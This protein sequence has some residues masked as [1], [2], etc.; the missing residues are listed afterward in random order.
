MHILHNTHIDQPQFLDILVLFDIVTAGLGFSPILR[1]RWHTKGECMKVDLSEVLSDLLRN[2]KTGLFSISVIDSNRLFKIFIREGDVYRLSFGNLR[3]AGCLAQFDELDFR[4]S[5]FIPNVD[6]SGEREAIPPTP[7][8]LSL[9]KFADKTVY[10]KKPGENGKDSSKGDPVINL[11]GILEEMKEAFVEQVGPAGLKFFKR[12]VDEKW[13]PGPT[14][15]RKDL[16]R[17]SELLKDVIED[18][19]DRQTFAAETI[20]ILSS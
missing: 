15:V 18:T 19:K 4:S 8:L 2:K 17:L 9:I 5:F 1:K 10:L 16:E 7:D 3:G 14:P 13:L 11:N 6:L 12:I 20:R